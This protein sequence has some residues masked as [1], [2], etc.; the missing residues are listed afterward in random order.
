MDGN[1]HTVA[2]TRGLCEQGDLHKAGFA[3]GWAPL[4]WV[5]SLEV[6]E[7]IPPRYEQAFLHNLHKLNTKGV[8]LSWA[9]V[10]QG[11]TGHVNEQDEPY[12]VA[13]MQALGY[14]HDEASSRALRASASLPWFRH[15]LYVFV[16]AS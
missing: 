4:E 7:H 3:E 5:L 16:R 1:S 14:V 15:G 6:G 11:G 13:K 12:V 8:I 10:G 9:R 2:M